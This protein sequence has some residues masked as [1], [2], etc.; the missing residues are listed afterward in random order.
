MFPEFGRRGE[1]QFNFRDKQLV[2]VLLAFTRARERR[3]PPIFWRQNLRVMD[4][5]IDLFQKT[6]D[7]LRALLPEAMKN[8]MEEARSRTTAQGKAPMPNP[9]IV[10]TAG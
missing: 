3:L 10:A 7:F 8:D 2:D 6:A 4:A 5:S 9:S 1:G